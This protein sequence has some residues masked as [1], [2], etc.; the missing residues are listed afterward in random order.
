MSGY[1]KG[2]KDTNLNDIF[3]PVFTAALLTEA[4]DMKAILGTMIDE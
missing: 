1:F 3:I 2:N 4:E